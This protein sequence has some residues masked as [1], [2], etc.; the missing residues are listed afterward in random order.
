MTMEHLVAV[1][2][3]Q[4]HRDPSRTRFVLYKNLIFLLFVHPKKSCLKIQIYF[5]AFKIGPICG[6]TLMPTNSP[7]VKVLRISTFRY[8]LQLL[9]PKFCFMASMDSKLFPRRGNLIQ[10][11]R[12]SHTGSCMVNTVLGRWHFFTFS[13][14]SSVE[15]VEGRPERGKSSTTS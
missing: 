12:K 9:L 14:F 1:W 2:L 5:V 4:L 7:V 10:R 13:T 3:F 15:D 8:G 11:N 6:D